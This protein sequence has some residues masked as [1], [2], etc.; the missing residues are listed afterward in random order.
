MSDLRDTGFSYPHRWSEIATLDPQHLATLDE[1]Q[2]DLEQFLYGAPEAFDVPSLLS[3]PAGA[4]TTVAY[5]LARHNRMRGRQVFVS[6][7]VQIAVVTSTIDYLLVVLP[8]SLWPKTQK[9][10]GSGAV[11]CAGASGRFTSAHVNADG[12]GSFA[13]H[14]E[15]AILDYRGVAGINSWAVDTRITRAEA[16]AV[17]ANPILAGHI[18][19]GLE[20]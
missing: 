9:P 20:Q 14:H 13:T 7:I 10:A 5:A 12:G 4:V 1:R 15:P 16:N 18:I 2:R 11:P 3:P 8:L 6:W 19:Y 17:G